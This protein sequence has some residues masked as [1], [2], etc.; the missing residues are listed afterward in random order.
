MDLIL[1][2]LATP[3]FTQASIRKEESRDLVSTL[4]N[5]SVLTEKT[6]QIFGCIIFSVYS[7]VLHRSSQHLESLLFFRRVL[8]SAY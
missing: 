1:Y 3:F 8:L 2:A 5:K 7:L 4:L 6:C